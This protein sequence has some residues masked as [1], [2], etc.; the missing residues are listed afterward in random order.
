[1]LRDILLLEQYQALHPQRKMKPASIRA[2]LHHLACFLSPP[3]MF[4]LPHWIECLYLTLSLG[5]TFGQK[6][7]KQ[8]QLVGV[9][10][11]AAQVPHLLAIP[12]FRRRTLVIS[13]DIESARIHLG[14]CLYMWHVGSHNILLVRSCMQYVVDIRCGITGTQEEP[15]YSSRWAT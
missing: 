14:Y 3:N 1:M 11:A 10:L 12:H 9:M 6:F 5:S 4:G 8:G 7:A 13:W 15:R 2:L